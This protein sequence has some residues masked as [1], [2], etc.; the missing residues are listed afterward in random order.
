MNANHRPLS[1]CTRCG[2]E[3][4]GAAERTLCPQCILLDD[5]D[6]LAESD[7]AGA[8]MLLSGVDGAA[9]LHATAEAP[10]RYT[11]AREHARGGIGAH[12]PGARQAA[13]A[14]GGGLSHT[15][16]SSASPGGASAIAPRCA[17]SKM[18]KIRGKSETCLT[19][20]K[21]KRTKPGT[22]LYVPGL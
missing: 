19:E 11:N 5:R 4:P 16:A 13:R 6:L 12:P 15:M 3:M 9:G 8:D 10:G 20:F 21:Q 2:R 14:R 1:R 7:T 18:Q 17:P 22:Y